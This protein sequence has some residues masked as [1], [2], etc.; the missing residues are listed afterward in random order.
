[1]IHTHTHT[2]TTI[3]F[4]VNTL[5]CCKWSIWSIHF[6]CHFFLSSHFSR[7]LF[8][9][10][11]WN[12]WTFKHTSVCAHT[13]THTLYRIDE[14]LLLGIFYGKN[15]CF[16]K[17]FQS[18]LYFALYSYAYESTMTLFIL[19]SLLL[20]NANNESQKKEKNSPIFIGIFMNGDE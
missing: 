3:H 10:W 20:P 8:T 6:L 16:Q 18:I 2:Q 11:K 17:K 19:R 7:S 4:Y 14:H 1:M 12:I 13:H 5:I 9:N 15:F